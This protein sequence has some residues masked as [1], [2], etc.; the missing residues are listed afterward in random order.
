MM[1]PLGQ[2]G[3]DGFAYLSKILSAAHRLGSDRLH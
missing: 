3:K 1:N 2:G